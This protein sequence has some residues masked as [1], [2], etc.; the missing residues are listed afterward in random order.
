[1]IGGAAALTR[2]GRKICPAK[3]AFDSMMIQLAWTF[4]KIGFVLRGRVAAP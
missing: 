3:R 4:A 1:M 2:H